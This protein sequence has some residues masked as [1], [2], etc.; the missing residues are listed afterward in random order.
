M[1][2]G[3]D[4]PL[5]FIPRDVAFLCRIPSDLP[6]LV[7][8]LIAQCFSTPVVL[9]LSHQQGHKE[10]CDIKTSKFSWYLKEA[11]NQF[12]TLYWLKGVGMI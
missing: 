4:L 5:P 7:G 3:N 6:K 1:A 8:L 12:K 10:N 11:D 9:K 2:W